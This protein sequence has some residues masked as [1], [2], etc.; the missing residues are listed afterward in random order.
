MLIHRDTYYVLFIH[1]HNT[2]T[3]RG[4]SSKLRRGFVTLMNHDRSQ[5]PQINDKDDQDQPGFHKRGARVGTGPHGGSVGEI[6]EIHFY[7]HRRSPADFRI[8]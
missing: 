5:F 2:Y 6:T 4:E 7:T 3:L 1:I 8:N